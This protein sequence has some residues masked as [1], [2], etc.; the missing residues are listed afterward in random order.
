MP[1]GRLGTTPSKCILIILHVCYLYILCTYVSPY[2]NSMPITRSC[3]LDIAPSRPQAV[4]DSPNI[5]PGPRGMTSISLSTYSVRHKQEALPSLLE[6]TVPMWWM[7][8]NNPIHFSLYI[9]LYIYTSLLLSNLLIFLTKNQGC[10]LSMFF[11]ENICE[12][13]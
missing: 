4:P 2:C 3:I 13:A 11:H 8:R 12:C 10:P 1:N 7:L 9:P 6:D 5:S